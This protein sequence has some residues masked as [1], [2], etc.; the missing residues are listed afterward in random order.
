MEN[1]FSNLKTVDMDKKNRIKQIT[2]LSCL[3]IQPCCA[4]VKV[5]G[6]VDICAETMSLQRNGDENSLQEQQQSI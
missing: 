2:T 3:N 1:L 4:G 5:I 6:F